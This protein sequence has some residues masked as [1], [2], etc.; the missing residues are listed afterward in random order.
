MGVDT[1]GS[2]PAKILTLQ[3]DAP[4]PPKGHPNSQSVIY[5][6]N[7]ITDFKEKVTMR[8][9]PSAPEISRRVRAHA[10]PL[11]D[12]SWLVLD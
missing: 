12:P 10:R 6:E 11:P 1:M 9:N 5:R 4:K 8:H 7:K 2:K 3:A